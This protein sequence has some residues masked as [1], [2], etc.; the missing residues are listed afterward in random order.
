MIFIILPLIFYNYVS[1]STVIGIYNIMC[2][3]RYFDEVTLKLYNDSTY[4]VVF[5]GDR[6]SWLWSAK[7]DFDFTTN[8][9]YDKYN[10]KDVKMDIEIIRILSNIK[11]K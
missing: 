5:W 3:D 7:S 11:N 10:G 8:V 6:E 9:P 4:R 1:D 2:V